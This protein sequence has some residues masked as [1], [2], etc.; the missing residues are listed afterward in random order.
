MVINRL[1]DGLSGITVIGA[2]ILPEEMEIDNPGLMDGVRRCGVQVVYEG[3]GTNLQQNLHSVS[4]LDN[5]SG[6][7]DEITLCLNDRDGDWMGGTAFEKERDL[8]VT[9]YMWNWGASK[10]IEKYHCGNFTVDDI[11]YQGGNNRITVKGVST[12]AASS[13]QTDPV[14]KT[15]KQITLK[16][17]AEEMMSKYGMIN[18]YFWGDD[19]IIE[20]AEQDSQTDSAFLYDICK[21]QGKALKI[22]K[23]GFVIF[24]EALYESRGITARFTK[25]DFIG[26]DYEWNTTLNGTYTGGVIS[27]KPPKQKEA[28]TVTIGEGPRFLHI[29][30]TVESEGEAIRTIRERV[31]AENKKAVTIRFKIIA[32]KDLV[33]SCNIEIYGLGRIDGKYYVDSVL[34]SIGPGGY[35]MDVTAHLILQRL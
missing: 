14:S 11:T 21:K 10:S 32:N 8:D 33:A 25:G 15:W 20:S 7:S 13:F 17:I 5:A 4:Y 12:P 16:Q 27:Y 18:L 24:D 26:G 3:S 29:R 23:K 22:Y 6:K 35:T 28:I 1:P 9:A 2:A 30:E 31:N 19:P 34:N